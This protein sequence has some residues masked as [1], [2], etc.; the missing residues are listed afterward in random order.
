MPV[1]VYKRKHLHVHPQQYLVIY[2]RM[3]GRD[4]LQ[5][6]LGEDGQ[7]KNR[8]IWRKERMVFLHELRDRLRKRET[9]KLQKDLF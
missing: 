4:C 9:G 6:H 5:V 1:C 8:G 2:L 7:E 3:C